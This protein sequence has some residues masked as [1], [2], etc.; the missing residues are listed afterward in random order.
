[1]KTCDYP[2][3]NIPS[4]TRL[5]VISLLIIASVEV[6]LMILLPLVMPVG[7]GY[8]QDLADALLLTTISAPFLWRLVACPLRSAAMVEASR[9]KALL[10]HMETAVVG[11]SD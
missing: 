7:K 2:V 6:L 8:L 10:E 4:P 11:F 3:R 5:F 9:T 1:M